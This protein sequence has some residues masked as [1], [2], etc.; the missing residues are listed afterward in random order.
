MV[1]GFLAEMLVHLCLELLDQVVGDGAAGLPG[2]LLERF[3]GPLVLVAVG[4]VEEAAVGGGGF[5]RA[6]VA[7]AL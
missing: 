1:G 3:E 6:A 2:R 7:L 4:D 5:D